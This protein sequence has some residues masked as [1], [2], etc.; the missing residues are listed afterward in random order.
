MTD[1]DLPQITRE[2]IADYGYT[3]TKLAEYLRAQGFT[4]TQPTVHRIKRGNTKV[5][6]EVGIAIVKLHQQ[7]EADR[8]H[9]S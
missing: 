5:S 2:L 7:L 9:A 3:E 4:T 1:F 6:W 8:A